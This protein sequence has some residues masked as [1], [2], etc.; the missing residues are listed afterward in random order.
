EVLPLL[1]DVRADGLR[2]DVRR[3]ERG[4]QALP[5]DERRLE[6][7]GDRAAAVRRVDRLDLV[8]TGRRGGLAHVGVTELAG[9]GLRLPLPDEVVRGDRRAVVPH[10]LLV[11]LVDDRLRARL[12]LLGR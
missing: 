12:D 5:V 3:V 2:R 6:R 9:A 4:E 1:R 11:Y 10:R 8:V 7:D